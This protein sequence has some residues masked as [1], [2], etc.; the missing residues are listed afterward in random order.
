LERAGVQYLPVGST[1]ARLFY[2]DPD[3]R[4]GKVVE[5]LAREDQWPELQEAMGEAGLRPPCSI[6]TLD[7]PSDVL[8]FFQLFSPCVFGR[9]RDVVVR[10]RFR[11]VPFGK[12]AARERAW[13]DA[14][15][16]ATSSAEMLLPPAEYLLTDAILGWLLEGGLLPLADLGF[17]LSRRGGAGKRLLDVF[18]REPLGPV[19]HRAF[20]V[21]SALLR[22]PM[23]A[24]LP[25]VPVASV[26]PAEAVSPRDWPS[27]LVFYLRACPKKSDRLRTFASLV[28]APRQWVS[29]YYARPF[30]LGLALRFALSTLAGFTYRGWQRAGFSGD[31][32]IRKRGL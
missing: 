28:S 27:P 20:L 24:G 19:F 8:S 26:N 30:R 14:E 12:A 11:L 17:L 10:V 22:M 13:E 29:S 16:V 23:P 4:G 3:W 32:E 21:A 2:P 31:D 6:P 5:I 7:G 18:R 9:G 1:A 25:P 15:R